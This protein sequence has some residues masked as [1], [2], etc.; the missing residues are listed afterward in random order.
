MFDLKQVILTKKCT[1]PVT[2]YLLEITTTDHDNGL[3]KVFRYT[4]LY[5]PDKDIS[6]AS[7]MISLWTIPQNQEN[8]KGQIGRH[9]SP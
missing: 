7:M 6:L 8:G 4:D 3:P 1:S 2:E 9:T 5:H